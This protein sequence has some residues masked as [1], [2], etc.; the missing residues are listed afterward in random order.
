MRE[1]FKIQTEENR[2]QDI[3][4]DGRVMLSGLLTEIQCHRV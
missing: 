2:L 1:K 4:T 3:V